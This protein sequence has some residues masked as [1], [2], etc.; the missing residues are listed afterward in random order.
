VALF[1]KADFYTTPWYSIV[2]HQ[3]Q[4]QS[5]ALAPAAQEARAAVY[6]GVAGSCPPGRSWCQ[7]A[8]W[9]G[10]GTGMVG[11]GELTDNVRE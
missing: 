10:R 11:R 8:E 9:V 5:A 7:S 4:A 3:E 2:A 1:V 6:Q